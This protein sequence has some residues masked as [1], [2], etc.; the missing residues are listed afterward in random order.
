MLFAI[1]VFAAAFGV[2]KWL[3]Q[4]EASSCLFEPSVYP[5]EDLP[6]AVAVYGRNN[7]AYLEKVLQ[8]VFAQRYPN[9]RVIYLDDHSDDGSFELAKEILGHRAEAIQ[10]EKELGK[11]ASFAKV[12]S[13]CKE[14]E[15]LLFIEGE[16]WLAHE[17]VLAR[18]N[19]YYAHPDLRVATGLGRRYPDLTQTFEQGLLS[20]YACMLEGANFEEL[21]EH[22]DQ[23]K[24]AFIPETFVIKGEK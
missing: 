16:E 9:F 13:L 21:L 3:S 4:R 12:K 14:N 8:S 2:G 6:F 23:S 1:F 15:I 10:N 17:W 5:V 11:E 7:G 24:V 20:G 19:Q 18:L 22:A